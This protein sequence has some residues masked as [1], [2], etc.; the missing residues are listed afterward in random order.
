MI[1]IGGFNEATKVFSGN[2]GCIKM[3]IA[4]IACLGI[5]GELMDR[6]YIFDTDGSK[7]KMCPITVP[8][9]DE[10]NQSPELTSKKP[11]KQEVEEVPR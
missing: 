6:N 11:G 5:A 2:G 8:V 1:N 4:A 3:A 10:V 7:F 9:I